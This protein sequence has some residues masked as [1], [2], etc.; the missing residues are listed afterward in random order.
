MKPQSCIISPLCRGHW[1]SVTQDETK[2]NLYWLRT[3]RRAP[4]EVD[5]K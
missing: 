4:L 1:V 5:H 3:Q 2:Q